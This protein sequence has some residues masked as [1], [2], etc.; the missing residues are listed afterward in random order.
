MVM[1]IGDT[2]TAIVMVVLVGTG[3]GELGD[4]SLL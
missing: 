4:G 1:A 3:E 2:V